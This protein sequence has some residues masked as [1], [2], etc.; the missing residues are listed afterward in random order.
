MVN[1]AKD[2]TLHPLGEHENFLSHT[3]IRYKMRDTEKF[4]YSKSYYS[5]IS[6][7]N[8]TYNDNDPPP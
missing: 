8:A 7:E 2:M 3:P 4:S 5:N 6:N 1:D